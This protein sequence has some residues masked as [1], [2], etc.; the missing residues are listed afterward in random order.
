MPRV[1]LSVDPLPKVLSI[2]VCFLIFG[3][4]TESRKAE[5]EI[6]ADKYGELSIRIGSYG[7]GVV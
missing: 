7:Q 1:S 3:C 2:L 6:V 5:T 4:T